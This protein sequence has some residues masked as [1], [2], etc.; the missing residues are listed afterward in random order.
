V[1]ITLRG[2]P[3][4][5]QR[6]PVLRR[7]R[8]LGVWHVLLERPDGRHFEAPI[9]WTDLRPAPKYRAIRGREPRLSAEHLL[10]LVERVQDLLLRK[11]DGGL[12][13]SRMAGAGADSTAAAESARGS[14]A[15]VQA[16]KGGV[17]A[18]RVAG[19]VVNESQRARGGVGKPRSPRAPR[20]KG[21]DR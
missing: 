4:F 8:K 20:R 16:R 12:K 14:G 1:L 2:H 9:E 21:G 15:G 6:L 18:S 7:T 13:P 5:G 19:G 3:H 11:M 10:L 17:V